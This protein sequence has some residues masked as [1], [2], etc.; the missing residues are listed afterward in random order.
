MRSWYALCVQP[1]RIRIGAFHQP[2]VLQIVLSD[3]HVDPVLRAIMQRAALRRRRRFARFVLLAN[4][5]LTDQLVA[6]LI[7]LFARR[8]CGD[9][10]KLSLEIIELRRKRVDLFERIRACGFVLVIAF[11]IPL[12]VLGNGE[13]RVQRDLDDRGRILVIIH[14]SHGTPV[15]GNAVRTEQK[16]AEQL[17]ALDLRFVADRFHTIGQ[18][19]FRALARVIEHGAKRGAKLCQ[20]RLFVSRTIEQ[21]LRFHDGRAGDGGDVSRTERQNADARNDGRRKAFFLQRG[22]NVMDILRHTHSGGSVL[23]DL[24]RTKPRDAVE[25]IGEPFPGHAPG[26][27]HFDLVDACGERIVFLCFGRVRISNVR[28]RN[29]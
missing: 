19:L 20:D 25:R 2:V 10:Q 24:L 1:D 17:I 9:V 8:T 3:E 21:I 11:E 23:Y 16:L 13:L 22:K 4:V 12:R 6:D 5:A 27:D 18:L 7:Q 14:D 15:R 28:K 26:G 29:A